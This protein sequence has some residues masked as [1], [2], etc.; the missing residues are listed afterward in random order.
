MTSIEALPTE[1][2]TI[3]K[4]AGRRSPE[5]NEILSKAALG[6][7]GHLS[8]RFDCRRREVLRARVIRQ[9]DLDD[10]WKPSFSEETAWIRDSNWKVRPVGPD[11]A[12]RRIQIGGPVDRQSVIDAMS[13]GAHVF[14]ADFED[15]HSPTW[16]NQLRGH[17]NIRDAVR[18]TIA[19]EDDHGVFH[20]LGDRT[21]HLA[22][23]PRGW[24]MLEHGLLIDGHPVSATLFDVGLFLFHNGRALIAHGDA[25][26]LCLPKI[27]S[28]FEARL[29]N[30]LLC[31]IEAELQLPTHA[32]RTTILIE[33]V[34]AAF[35]M[36]EPAKPVRLCR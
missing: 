28:Y 20:Q 32:V 23:R 21:A 29:W 25:P 6:F 8:R 13:S 36:D 2:S 35:Q 24:H 15:G 22:V 30:D 9:S 27:E 14:M 4:I 17:V 12:D 31:E 1:T 3:I 19:Y 34:L 5:Y 10:G 11:L 7:I 26:H 18:G 33:N 16:D